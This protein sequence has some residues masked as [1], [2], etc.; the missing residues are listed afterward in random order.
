VTIDGLNDNGGN[1][2]DGDECLPEPEA[3][4]QAALLLVESLIH[5]LIAR[6]VISV[7]DAVDIVGIA[8]DANEN[9]S[10]ELQQV[11]SVARH[12]LSLLESVKTSLEID[13]PAT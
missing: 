7:R 9:I 11:R 2:P 3:Q 12:S 10:D 4:G 5:G 1:R 6:S 8:C 13:L